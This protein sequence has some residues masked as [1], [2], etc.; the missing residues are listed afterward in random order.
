MLLAPVPTN[1]QSNTKHSQKHASPLYLQ[2][3]RKKERRKNWLAC[4]P[5]CVGGKIHFSTFVGTHR[6]AV[7]EANLHTQKN[8]LRT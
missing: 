2:Q 4:F 7:D 1:S 8:S 3:H 6:A 5:F